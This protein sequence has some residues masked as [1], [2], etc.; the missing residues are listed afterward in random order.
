[1]MATA[2]IAGMAFSGHAD[3]VVRKGSYTASTVLNPAT[4]GDQV[5]VVETGNN[6]FA[7]AYIAADGQATMRRFSVTSNGNSITGSGVTSTSGTATAVRVAKYGDNRAIMA[8]RVSNGIQLSTWDVSGTP[9]LWHTTVYSTS[10]TEF[11]LFVVED[12]SGS[13]DARV[14][15]ATAGYQSSELVFYTVNLDNP[16]TQ[17][18][19]YG[20]SSTVNH[21]AGSRVHDDR[22]AVATVGSSTT[23]LRTFRFPTATSIAQLSS[24]Q[25]YSTDASNLDLEADPGSYVLVSALVS[26]AQKETVCTINADGTINQHSTKT[27]SGSIDD[28]ASCK[29]GSSKAAVATRNNNELEVSSWKIT[30]SNSASLAGTNDEAGYIRQCKIAK[31]Y[32]HPAYNRVVAVMTNSSGNMQCIV[33]DIQLSF[34]FKTDDAVE[35][36][37]ENGL[38]GNVTNYPNPCSSNTSFSFDLS[39]ESDVTLKVYNQL[40]A[41]VDVVFSGR[42]NEGQQQIQWDASKLPAGLYWYALESGAERKTGKLVVE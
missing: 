41:E 12:N 11:D 16:I 31:I 10:C 3:N 13:T 23:S 42:L 35:S 37:Q 1:M 34:G 19:V 32:T 17:R 40:G 39:Q 18:Y 24:K 25:L 26:G 4:A 30:S 7:T 2:M 33:Y 6:T 5:D 38:I 29:L 22:F 36:V 9:V 15:L 8:A 14:I 27:V 21:I 20:F 28:I